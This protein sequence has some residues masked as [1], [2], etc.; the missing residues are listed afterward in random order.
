MYETARGKPLSRRFRSKDSIRSGELEAGHRLPSIRQFVG[1]LRIAPGTVA[2]AYREL[3]TMGLI[4][5]NRAGGTRVL[6]GISVRSPRL[7]SSARDAALQA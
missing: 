6:P 3:E 2:R 7:I 4:T 1:D 5:S